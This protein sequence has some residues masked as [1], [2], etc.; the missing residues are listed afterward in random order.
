MSNTLARQVDRGLQFDL[1]T[2]RGTGSLKVLSSFSLYT[3]TY[4]FYF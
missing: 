1:Y 3:H 2:P 4:Q